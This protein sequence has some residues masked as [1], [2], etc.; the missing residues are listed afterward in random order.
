[1]FA[2]IGDR[3]VVEGKH[4]GDTRRIGVITAVAHADGRPPYEVRWLDDGRTSMIVPGP[5]A[6]IEKAAP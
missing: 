3:I 5:E 2:R 6:R 1:M 4:L